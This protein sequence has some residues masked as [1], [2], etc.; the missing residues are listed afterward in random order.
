[1]DVLRHLD[2]ISP[3]AQELVALARAVA[4]QQ[5]SAEARWQHEASHH[6]APAAEQWPGSFVLNDNG[7]SS[8][9]LKGLEATMSARALIAQLQAALQTVL[10]VC[11][12]CW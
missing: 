10:Q 9:A 2:F 1:M 5:D 8:A 12:L 4:L 6:Q 7:M 11:T 3:N